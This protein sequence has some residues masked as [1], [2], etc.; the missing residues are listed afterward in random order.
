MDK[1]KACIFNIQ[2][3]SLH[4]GPGI[5][6]SIFFKGCPLQCSWCSNPES[7]NKTPEPIWDNVKKKEITTGEYVTVEDLMAVIRKDV[8][9][10]RESQGGVTVTG[11]ELLIQNECV[12]ELLKQCRKENIHTACETSGY[13]SEK[14]F[15]QLIDHTDLL[16]MDL[17][18]H[19]T[20]KHQAETGVPLAPIL[21]NLQLAVKSP[22]KLL[23]R[24]PVIPGFNDT[25]QDA[26][27]FANLL[28][29]HKVS[30][31]ELLPFHQFGKSKYSYLNRLYAFKDAKP[32]YAEDLTFYQ[33][34]IKSYHIDCLLD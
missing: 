26:H 3:F 13:A 33:D 24:V 19:D 5:R 16:I 32:L 20:K 12:I 1:I 9:Y 30:H 34:I 6:T 22:K 10:Y 23:V 21:K 8:D 25:P 28:K 4:D 2:R 17:K 29:T 11:G 18:H 27:A 7:Q 14:S 31:I 15:Q